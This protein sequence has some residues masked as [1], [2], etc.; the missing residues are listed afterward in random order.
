MNRFKK[1]QKQIDI[2]LYLHLSLVSFYFK[3]FDKFMEEHK[4]ELMK[5]EDRDD[6][7]DAEYEVQE[8]DIEQ[9]D[10]EVRNGDHGEDFC[11]SALL[12]LILSN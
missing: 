11:S 7:T 8:M 12:W 2:G 4:S 6:L 5:I 1:L 9:A 10:Q 3:E